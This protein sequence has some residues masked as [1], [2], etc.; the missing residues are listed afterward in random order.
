M[1]R[2]KITIKIS[3]YRSRF[4]K[5]NEWGYCEPDCRLGKRKRLRECIDARVC[6][7]VEGYEEEWCDFTMCDN[8]GNPTTMAPKTTVVT[9]PETISTTAETS[10]A[11]S[12]L[13]TVESSA[14]TTELVTTLATEAPTEQPSSSKS[15]TI[16]TTEKKP[17]TT[18]LTT[19]AGSRADTTKPATSA[20][21]TP[22]ETAES[23]TGVN[24]Q[25]DLNFTG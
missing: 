7:G 4:V 13:T 23:D 25:L 11:T 6:G 17:E 18:C 2:Y 22:A 24:I 8:D 12:A 5:W 21:T 16:T 10:A 14:Q 19:T 20:S 3:H 1:N 9:V 15:T